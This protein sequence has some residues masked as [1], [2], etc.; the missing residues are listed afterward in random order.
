LLETLADLEGIALIPYPLLSPISTG[1]LDGSLDGNNSV[2]WHVDRKT[3]EASLTDKVCALFVVQPNNPTGSLLTEVDAKYLLALAEVHHLALI[4]DEVF[5]D[6]LH[7]SEKL[8]LL[9]SSKTLVFTLNGL[10]KLLGLPQLKL[11]WIHVDGEPSLKSEAK[12]HL[13]WICD[14]YLSVNTASQVACAELLRRRL[15]FQR[16]LWERL[17][18]NLR[19]L[20]ELTS[21]DPVWIEP[22]WPEGGWCIPVRL[23][24]GL[25][26]AKD[27]ETV[28][29]QLL[30][31][32]GV[33][34]HPGYFFDFDVDEN[35]LVL[36]LLPEPENF[37]EG[38]RRILGMLRETAS[39]KQ[40]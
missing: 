21:E 13:E 5:A 6:Y 38:I 40:K 12:R 18:T 17:Q 23:L 19:T 4:V 22:L 35:V 7:R 11:A 31:S 34:V 39:P 24:K 29:V 1:T 20:R 15:E 25:A 36:S 10:S 28:A 3:L 32:Q 27:D 33:L 2:P 30:Q 26:G 9:R 8:S 37:R 14:A 16:P